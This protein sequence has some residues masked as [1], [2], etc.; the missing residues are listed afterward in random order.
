VCKWNH[1]SQMELKIGV[2]KRVPDDDQVHFRLI[3]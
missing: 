2:I 1:K 3:A